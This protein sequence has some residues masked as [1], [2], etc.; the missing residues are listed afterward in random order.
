MPTLCPAI[1]KLP[2]RVSELGFALTDQDAL[3][4][5]IDTE[6]QLTPELAVAVAQSAGLGVTAIF[7]APPAELTLTPDGFRV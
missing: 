3:L 2:P 5:K 7:P 6:A 1:V 4:P